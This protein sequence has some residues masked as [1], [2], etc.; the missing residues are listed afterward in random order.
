VTRPVVVHVRTGDQGDG[1]RTYAI[2]VPREVAAQLD[3]KS[4]MPELLPGGTLIYRPMVA[5]YERVE[6]R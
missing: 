4:Y 3:G 6:E 5:V 2:S 1:E